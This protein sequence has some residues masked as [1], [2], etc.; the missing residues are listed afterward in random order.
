MPNWCRNILVLTGDPEVL[1]NFKLIAARTPSSFLSEV[2][3]E[4]LNFESLPNE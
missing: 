3:S 4:V 1:K 2:R